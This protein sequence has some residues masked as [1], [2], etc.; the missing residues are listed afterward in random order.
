[1]PT[2][3]VH[4][5]AREEVRRDRLVSL[6]DRDGR[7]EEPVARLVRGDLVGRGAFGDRAC[8]AQRGAFLRGPFGDVR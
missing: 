1:M 6:D 5:F 8:V 4:P 7:D 2:Q 3:G